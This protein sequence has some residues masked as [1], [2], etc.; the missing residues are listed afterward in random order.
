MMRYSLLPLISF[1]LP[2]ANSQWYQTH[3]LTPGAYWH[4][5]YFALLG[6]ASYGN[7][8]TKCPNETFTEE[9][10]LKNFPDSTRAPWEV[11]STFGPTPSGCKGFT[12]IVPEMNK[13]LIIFSGNLELEQNLPT[14]SVGWEAIGLG[15]ECPGCLVNAF[16]AQGYMECKN[17]TNNFQAIRDAYVGQGL[18]FAISGH[19]LGGMHSQIASVD[20]NVQQI[21]YYSHSQ[22]QP[23]TFNEA[24]AT[25]YNVRFN[26]EAG[27][28]AVA[29][30]DLITEI[31]PES[32][33]YTH[34]GTPFY[35]Y[36][37]NSTSTGMNWEI[38]WLEDGLGYA[39]C[40]P[41]DQGT[42]T[43]LE[44]HYFYFTN[45]GDCGATNHQ[46][47]TMIDA[48]LARG[49]PGGS[50]SLT[51]VTSSTSTV[52]STSTTSSI[53]PTVAPNVTDSTPTSPSSTPTPTT[54]SEAAGG[55][56]GA[57]TWSFSAPLMLL[58]GV[59]SL[60]FVM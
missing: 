13:A 9:A 34:A 30:N 53:L 46:N 54:P 47:T 12:A 49:N 3:N 16:A 60:F 2:T 41:R 58:G 18:V 42:S 44:D 55:S 15:E 37:Y 19:G 29:G 8:N 1:L 25:F 50:V 27:E 23:R 5:R 6:M 17:A 40:M 45:V 26:G 43:S 32:E 14:D 39:A 36:G 24:G 33:N 11:V 35:Y 20:F 52:S 59:V 38:C 51:A 56:S 22:G 28:R 10:M 57:S 21:A 31:I 7:Y 48:F 4:N